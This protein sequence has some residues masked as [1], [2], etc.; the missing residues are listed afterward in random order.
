MMTLE[1]IRSFAIIGTT[2]NQLCAAL[3][4][5]MPVIL[6]PDTWPGWLGE[7]PADDERTRS[8]VDRCDVAA[9]NVK[10]DQMLASSDLR[11]FAS[12]ASNRET[13]PARECT[14]RHDINRSHRDPPNHLRRPAQAGGL[15]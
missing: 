5:R 8:A 13:Q 15:R 1:R 10:A 7:E 14:G 4:N 9:S 12:G 6:A 2:P 11:L 3:H